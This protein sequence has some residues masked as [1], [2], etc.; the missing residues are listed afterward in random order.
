MKTSSQN[1]NCS[2]KCLLVF[3]L[4]ASLGIWTTWSC[5]EKI[6][7]SARYVFKE[8]TI[9]SYL[10]NHSEDYSTYLDILFRVPVSTASATTLG[11]LLSARGH[12]T[13]FAPTNEAIEAY[14]DTLVDE[15]II[16]YS[17][18][19]AFSDSDKLDSIRRVIAYNSI[20]DNGDTEQAYVTAMVSFIKWRLSSHLRK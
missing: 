13:V 11:Q 1:G 17:S 9:I 12:Y 19:E 7:S 4:L 16:P 6:E 3:F 14:L 18:W 10:E 5:S 2:R 8:Y 15:N 20:I